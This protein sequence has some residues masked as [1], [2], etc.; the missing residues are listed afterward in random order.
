MDPSDI[1]D[2]VLAISDRE[3]RKAFLASH[4]SE[5]NDETA[6]VF[7][8]RADMYLR[9]DI[10]RSLS[11]CEDLLYQAEL[12]QDPSQRA[13]GL[14]AKANARSIG[15]SRYEEAIALYDDAAKIYENEGLLVEQARSQIGKVA[16]LALLDRYDEAEA[17]GLWARE[18]LQEHGQISSLATLT[19]NL[20]SMYAYRGLDTKALQFFNEA[21]DLYERLG[22][23]GEQGRLWVEHN[24]AVILRN[25]GDFEAAIQAGQT[26]HDQLKRL[27]Q[28][29]AA[30]KAK[31]NLAMTYFSLGEFNRALRL[32][33]EVREAFFQ[34]QRQRD[35]AL[36]DLYTTDCLLQLR[37]F[38]EVLAKCQQ[39]KEHFSALGSQRFVGQAMLNEAV[40]L[41]NLARPTEA[42][43]SLSDARKLFEHENNPTLL[44][45]IDLERAATE[46]RLGH[47]EACVR[48]SLRCA[49]AFATL[50]LS[51]EKAQSMLVAAKAELALGKVDAAEKHLHDTIQIENGLQVPSL[52]YQV[53]HLMGRLKAQEG[54]MGSAIQH[55]EQ[56]I[57]I[58]ERV[59]GHLMLEFRAGFIEDKSIVYED[60]VRLCLDHG[61]PQ[62]ALRFA[63]RAKSRA[64]LDLLAYRLDLGVHAQAET[65]QP[66]VDQ[67]NQIR[68]ERDRLY[69]RWESDEEAREG[70]EP[71]WKA[72]A[73]AAQREILNL[74]ERITQ[75]WHRLLVR[76]ADYASQAALWTVRTEP[77]QQHL[78]SGT[79]LI[80]YYIADQSLLVFLISGE[81]IHVQRLSGELRQ[82]RDAL[83]LLQLNMKAVPKSSPQQR[84]QLLDNA[85]LHLRELHNLL[86]EPISAE[87]SE[88]ERLIVVPHG[89]LHYV[90]FHALH[91]GHSY[92]LARH[93]I[94]YLPSASLLRY[95]LEAKPAGEGSLAL[96]YSSGGRLPHAVEEART[97]SEITHGQAF[98]ESHAT[99]EILL[100]CAE[101]S[102][103]LHLAAHGD[104][105]PDNP[106]FSGLALADGWLSTLDIFGLKLR[107]SLAT[108]SACQTGRHV[109]GGG[110]ELLGLMRAFLAAGVPTLLL[111]QWTVED[112]S[113]AELM[114]AFYKNLKQGR[115][116]AGALRMAQIALI[117]EH[118]ELDPGMDHTFTHPYYW[119]PF[120]LVGDPG[121]LE[122]TPRSEI[123]EREASH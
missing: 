111:T 51:V 120:F 85:R 25:L 76:N 48:L 56:A 37:R 107:A 82:V 58:L 49:E 109:I 22:P 93:Q 1:V 6:Q 60:A 5:L 101:N 72:E 114:A 81:R 106:L 108:L 54:N 9:S 94:S 77:V 3:A 4:H 26:A 67:L 91:D 73:I 62:A 45:I 2:Q 66:L 8:E 20:A 46:L 18:V 83:R 113:T 102:E 115:S 96:A 86:L 36:V 29:I 79:M 110:D 112:R 11:A 75:L 98:L 88:F 95:C 52:A 17:N 23:E 84:P 43:Q 39:V 64:L 55:L 57:Q 63:E 90:P 16:A 40:A 32:L 117:Q 105:R 44:A 122:R 42:L 10:Q 21:G 119:A 70:S 12:T 116:K 103:I 19:M 87:V 34:D 30:A 69:R 121:Q 65:D 31:Q 7:K 99:K 27:G 100:K 13:L 33:D 47:P 68:A 53:K 35:A 28:T 89:P 104:F 80:E 78:D 24:R 118:P 41:N 50:D 61:D 15:Q 38:Q 59:S 74:E 92:L 123:P 71:A 97:V 14:L